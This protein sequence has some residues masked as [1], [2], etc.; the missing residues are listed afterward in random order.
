MLAGQFVGFHAR[1]D[2]GH[3][4]RSAQAVGGLRQRVEGIHGGH[5]QQFHRLAFLLRHFHHV[6]EQFLFVIAENLV[7]GKLVFAGA[8]GDGAHG[9]HHDVVPPQIGFFEHALQVLHAMVIAHGH[10][11]ASGARVQAGGVICA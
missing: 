6:A 5:H 4:A 2:A 10:Q 1:A 11:H 7:F 3:Q 8:G 9:H